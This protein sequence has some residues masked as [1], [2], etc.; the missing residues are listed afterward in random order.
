MVLWRWFR[1]SGPMADLH[2]QGEG[3]DEV[4][5]RKRESGAR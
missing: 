3:K 1:R 4:D 2:G 5:Q